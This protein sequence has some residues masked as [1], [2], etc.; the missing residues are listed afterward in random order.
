MD[1][2]GGRDHTTVMHAVR[3]IDQRRSSDAR[4]D[5]DLIR[6]EEVLV[7]HDLGVS[8]QLV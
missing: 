5:R 6:L 4:L 1:I 8:G 3:T 2:S 7:G